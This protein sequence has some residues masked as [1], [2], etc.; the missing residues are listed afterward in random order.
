MTVL[1]MTKREDE[2][3][4]PAPLDLDTRL[5]RPS[6]PRGG[7][8]F[9]VDE[10]IWGHRLY[11]DQSP[12]LTLLECLGVA[13]AEHRANRAFVEPQNGLLTYTPLVQ[14]RLRNILFN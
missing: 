11:D 7:P 10:A 2:S 12:W 5:P 13:Y 4:G 3:R 8:E 6:Y 14:L 1:T 9:W